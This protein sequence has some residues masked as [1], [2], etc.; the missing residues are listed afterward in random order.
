MGESMSENPSTTYRFSSLEGMEIIYIPYDY[1]SALAQSIRSDS[2]TCWTHCEGTVRP[3][4]GGAQVVKRLFCDAIQKFAFV[5][6]SRISASSKFK[7]FYAIHIPHT[8]CENL[9]IPYPQIISPTALCMNM[10][11]V[12]VKVDPKVV[13]FTF[14]EFDSIFSKSLQTKSIPSVNFGP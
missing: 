8:A 12:R 2:G 1:E 4:I 6:Q 5:I 7:N 10:L 14:I 11:I 13:S 3:A 9:V